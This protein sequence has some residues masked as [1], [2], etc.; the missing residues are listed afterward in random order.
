MGPVRIALLSINA[1]VLDDVLICIN[2]KPTPTAMIS[3]LA[4]SFGSNKCP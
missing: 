3:L 1:T 4:C 2:H